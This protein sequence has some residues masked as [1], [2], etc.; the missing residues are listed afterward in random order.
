MFS[1]MS[2]KKSL[3]SET[4]ETRSI[5]STAASVRLKVSALKL[6]LAPR[7]K[8][9]SKPLPDRVGKW[10]ARAIGASMK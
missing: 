3:H 1:I 9:P 8:S 4:T 2:D 6:K 10:E 5:A 7:A